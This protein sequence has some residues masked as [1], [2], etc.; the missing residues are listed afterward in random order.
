MKIL[1][2]VSMLGNGHSCSHSRSGI[3][4]VVENLALGLY[5][6]ENC[7]TT[8]CTSSGNYKSCQ[9]Y[10]DTAL[11]LHGYKLCQP[12][13][14]LASMYNFVEPLRTGLRKLP[15]ENW[16][17]PLR[18]L[19][20]F[21]KKYIQPLDVKDIK[22][23]DIFHAPNHA[24]P[25]QLLQEKSISKFITIHDLIAHIHPEYCTSANIAYKNIILDSIKPDSFVTC[26]SKATREDFLTFMP[27]FDPAR[28]SVV[29]LAAGNHF[30]CCSDEPLL[31]LVRNKYGIPA[32]SRY[33][34]ALSTLQ[35]RKNFERLI[36][37]FIKLVRQEHI[38]D[39]YLVL[40]G[41]DGWGYEKIYQEIDD[42]GGIANR[43]IIT[44]YVPDEDLA[45]LY[46]GALAFLYPSLYEG[47]GLPTLEAMQCGT[48]VITSNNSSLQQ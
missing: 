10:L 23:A 9:D 25:A 7:Q 20:N 35:P 47:F 33:L 46:S 39:L 26:V 11:D 4:R 6:S 27:F 30:Y 41:A 12:V 3:F 38:N 34:L 43:I 1:Y 40:T 44:G 17:N 21:G 16:K 36:K 31:Q 37:S 13:G 14:L 45:P 32:E 5:A 2:D 18:K 19:Y 28:V 15:Q 48:P 42:A 8:F 24:I 29:Y 22:S